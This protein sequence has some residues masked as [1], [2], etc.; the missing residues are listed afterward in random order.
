VTVTVNNQLTNRTIP[1]G[2]V[3]VTNDTFRYPKGYVLYQHDFDYFDYA[4]INRDVTLYT[5]PLN[6]IEDISVRTYFLED[7]GFIEYNITRSHTNLGSCYVSLEGDGGRPVAKSMVCDNG[8]LIVENVH[9][10]W[11]A[12]SGKSPIGYLYILVVILETAEEADFYR[13]PVGF[14]TVGWTNSSILINGV[15][16]YMKGFGMHEDSDIRGRGFDNV[17]LLRDMNLIGWIGA[18]AIRTSHYPY[19]TE[20]LY[21]ADRR[22]IMV[23][24]ETPACSLSNFDNEIYSRHLATMREIITIYKNHP[25]IVMWSLAN[26]PQTYRNEST[27]YFRNLVNAVRLMDPSRP[28]TFV[29]SQQIFNEKAVGN[30]DVV[31]LNRY[32]GWYQDGGKPE[33]VRYQTN[34]EVRAWSS[35]YN[36]PVIVTEYGAGALS[37]LHNL[38]STMWTED[39]QR[40]LLSEHF[41]AFDDLK[42]QSNIAGEMIW[43][44]ADFNTPQEYIRPG[45]CD[46]GLFTRSRQPK[47]AAHLVRARYLSLH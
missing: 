18:T 24:L 43:N 34:A 44:F 46:K 7:T 41:K 21:Q 5:T 23:I 25:S 19:S 2:F 38:P 40:E 16:T 27:L 35:K 30:M 10:W 17:I 6:Y 31:C 22:G 26:E 36:A 1:Q 32:S 37:G 28:V 39:Y 11:P 42:N 29:T 8:L 20:F 47:S 12:G 15:P 14:R 4:G 33:L 9:L 13:L 45:G 3:T